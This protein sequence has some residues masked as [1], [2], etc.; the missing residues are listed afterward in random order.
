MVASVLSSGI[1]QASS[2]KVSWVRDTLDTEIS[3]KQRAQSRG[4]SVFQETYYSGFI[5][6]AFRK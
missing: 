5:V 6:A 1:L 4:S 2:W 3:G